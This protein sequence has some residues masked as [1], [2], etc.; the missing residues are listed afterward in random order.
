LVCWDVFNKRCVVHV[1]GLYFVDIFF[2]LLFYLFY[3][4]YFILFYFILFHSMLFYFI[5]FHSILFYLFIYLLH[6]YF[7]CV[8]YFLSAIEQ[9]SSCIK[10]VTHIKL[11]P[12]IPLNISTA[13][14]LT[15]TLISP[16]NLNGQ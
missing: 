6:V 14:Y 15:L 10:Q 2:Y 11:C 3:L 12:T 8:L 5:L 9:I 1:L 16:L 4:F 7:V 13:F